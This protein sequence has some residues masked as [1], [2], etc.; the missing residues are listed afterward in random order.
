MLSLGTHLFHY[1]TLL[2][3]LSC[4]IF[5]D[6]L[7]AWAQGI[8]SC[9]MFNI[10]DVSIQKEIRL[11]TVS[12]NSLL[13]VSFL[14]CA[15]VLILTTLFEK[16]TVTMVSQGYHCWLN[17]RSILCNFFWMVLLMFLV[18][19]K[20]GRLRPSFIEACGVKQDIMQGDS[21]VLLDSSVCT[22]TDFIYYCQSFF[23]GH[24]CVAW[25]T[26]TIVV[27]K[28]YQ[29]NNI[30]CSAK[31]LFSLLTTMLACWVSWTRYSDHQ[32]HLSDIMIGGCV[33]VTFAAP[34]V[35]AQLI[36]HV[37]TD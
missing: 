27:G 22:K 24:T 6:R 8:S 30:H 19:I 29:S 21:D 10:S 12:S 11:E 17:L 36:K 28:L 34:L 15:L 9:A 33:G 31:V 23:S 18:K 25:Y 2:T 14:M 13:I 4:V 26:L 7:A 32:H 37:K 35:L 5:Y 3:F 1:S 20:W 16:Q